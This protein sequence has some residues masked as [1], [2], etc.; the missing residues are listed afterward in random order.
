MTIRTMRSSG[1]IL[2]FLAGIIQG[3]ERDRG[4]HGQEYRKHI[5]EV[6]RQADPRYEI[7]CPVENHPESIHYDNL[8]AAEVFHHHVELVN[9]SDVLVV[10]L[11]EASMGSSIEMW[12]ASR[13]G[14]PVVCVS[15]MK[16]N[17]VVR[18]LSDVICTDLADFS[19]WIKKGGMKELLTYRSMDGNKF[20]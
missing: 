2:I 13:A 18:I 19:E 12:E 14:V 16:E 15:P 6:L 8:K 9:K 7:Y 20:K 10:Y 11:P 4:V 17:W 1:N 3:S 5:K